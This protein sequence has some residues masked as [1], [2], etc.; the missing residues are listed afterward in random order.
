MIDAPN[1]ASRGCPPVADGAS[2]RLSECAG[3]LGSHRRSVRRSEFGCNRLAAIG[4][5]ANA[6]TLTGSVVARIVAAP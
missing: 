6:K 1:S 3:R 4:W 5:E 2:D